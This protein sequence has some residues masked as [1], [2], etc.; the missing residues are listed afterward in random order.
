MRIPTL[1]ASA[2]KDFCFPNMSRRLKALAKACRRQILADAF[3]IHAQCGLAETGAPFDVAID[4]EG[5]F[6]VQTPQGERL[7]RAGSFVLS[8]EGEIS[9]AEGYPLLSESGGPISIPPEAGTV[10]IGPD[11]SIAC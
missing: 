4:G 7:T 8:N 3:S 1:P 11:G 5:Y 6:A 2:A 9:T 10:T